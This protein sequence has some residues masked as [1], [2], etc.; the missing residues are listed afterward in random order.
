MNIEVEETHDQLSFIM[1]LIVARW[2]SSF[3]QA[4]VTGSDTHTQPG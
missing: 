4:Q 3:C 2:I 1:F